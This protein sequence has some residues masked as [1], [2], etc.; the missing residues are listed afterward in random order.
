MMGCT[1][2]S[3]GIYVRESRDDNGENY[4]TIENQRDLLVD[5]AVSH[6]LGQVYAVYTDDNVS[7]SAFERR[8]LDRL[9]EDVKASRINLLLLKD[10]SRLGRN[11]AKTL[12]FLDF[13]EEYGVRIVSSDGR[14]DSLRD[15]DTVGIET[16]I[17]ER[18]VRDLSRKIRSSL[19][20]KI[21]K[22][23]Y[24]G[25]AP[26]GYRKAPGGKNRLQPD[27]AEAETVRLI[28][29]LYRSGMGY[30]AIASFLDGRGCRAPSGSNWNR[31]TVRRILSSRVY[32]G[33]T[34]QGVSERVSF[35]SKKTKRLPKE[36]WTITEGTHEAIILQEEFLEVQKIREL[37]A[38]GRTPGKSAF[39]ILN[40]LIWCG[41]CGSAMY[42][43]EKGDAVTYICGNYFRNGREKC[44]RH[45]VRED[46]LVKCIFNELERLFRGEE[47][48]P[49]L[50][51]R[52]KVSGILNNGNET[53]TDRVRK[54]LAAYRRQQEIAYMDRLEGRITEQLFARMN[55]G[56]EERISCAEKELERLT[57]AESDAMDAG[58]LIGEAVESI[59]AGALTNELARILVNRI[60]V[61]DDEEYLSM[62]D[63][64]GKPGMNGYGQG[65]VIIDFSMNNK[66]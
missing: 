58:R 25:K 37:K 20:F 19:R 31:I 18:Y 9:K 15:N 23:E 27:E 46:K 63:S 57:L 6:R 21:Q 39:H 43:R 7:G 4:E 11:N 51:E 47:Y 48:L 53:A 38:A 40:G 32:M 36:E 30:S 29:R 64:S 2:N 59:L 45:P 35:K 52:M 10:L 26:F 54:Q 56:V 34:V 28:Y 42:A 17:N 33:D 24:L 60:T 50:T 55:K 3:I 22:G 5:Y 1:S 44:T 66:V 65:M 14:Y 13:L 49:R 16:W 8:G 41:G 62:P 61:Y 12:Q